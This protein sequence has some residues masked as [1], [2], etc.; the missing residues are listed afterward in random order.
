MG[1]VEAAAAVAGGATVAALTICRLAASIEA[2][3]LE[4]ALY[5][6]AKQSGCMIGQIDF[7]RSRFA[8]VE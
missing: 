8:E 1:V 7:H 5:P 2:L 3:S 6:R 4:H